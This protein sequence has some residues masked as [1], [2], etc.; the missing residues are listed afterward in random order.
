MRWNS[1]CQIVG[2]IYESRGL[3]SRDG[4]EVLI[5]ESVTKRGLLAIYNKPGEMINIDVHG[6]CLVF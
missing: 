5:M 2:N 3:L 4:K 1:R 6:P